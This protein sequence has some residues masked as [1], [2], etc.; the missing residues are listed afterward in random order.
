MMRIDYSI[1]TDGP[2]EF[3]ISVGGG[4]IKTLGKSPIILEE[5]IEYE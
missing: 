4:E 1:L 5:S 2:V 3:E